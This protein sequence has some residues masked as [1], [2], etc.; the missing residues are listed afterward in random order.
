MKESRDLNKLE[1]HDLFADLKAFEFEK[2]QRKEEDSRTEK[3]AL[4]SVERKSKRDDSESEPKS[5]KLKKQKVLIATQ[6]RSSWTESDSE[7][8]E[9]TIKCFMANDVEE[10]FDFGSDR[11]G[12]HG[13]S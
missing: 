6:S 1:L 7:D 4:P 12:S 13:R 11:I 8:E 10:A 2:N 5:T 9:E 3:K